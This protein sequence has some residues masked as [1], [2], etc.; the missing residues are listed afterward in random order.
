MKEQRAEGFGC[1]ICQQTHPRTEFDGVRTTLRNG[2]DWIYA[3]RTGELIG[4]CPNVQD[5][6]IRL[7]DGTI[8]FD[9]DMGI[10]ERSL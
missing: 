9:T 7:D 6:T 2:R 10:L 4:Y 8:V 3:G 1:G 5:W